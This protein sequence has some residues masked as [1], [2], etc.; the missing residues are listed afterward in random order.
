M[1]AKKTTAPTRTKTDLENEIAT[2]KMQINGSQGFDPKA[3]E[4]AKAHDA[5]VRKAVEGISVEKAVSEITKVTLDVSRSL[6][7]VSEQLTAK[8]QELEDVSKAVEL[9][10]KRLEELHSKDVVASSIQ[11]LLAEFDAKSS[12]LAALIADKKAAWL[13]EEQAHN[14]SVKER[15]EQLLKDRKHEQTDYDYRTSQDRKLA[16]DAFTEKVRLQEVQNRITQ[17]DLTKSWALREAE[18]KVNENAFIAAKAEI[19]AFPAKLKKEVDAAVAIATNSVKKDYLHEKEILRKDSDAV[20]AL[21]TQKIA[22]LEASNAA[23]LSTIQKLQSELAMANK[24]V[25]EIASKALESASGAL[26]LDRVSNFASRSSDSSNGS[27]KS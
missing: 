25:S 16:N 3:L 8:V 13:K 11:S 26:A 5:S 10:Q 20:A 1:A 12:E 14:L 24:Q 23:H 21:M 7:A 19:D 17:E 4:V 27:R 18:L 9:E 22:T 6:S 2:L 15:D